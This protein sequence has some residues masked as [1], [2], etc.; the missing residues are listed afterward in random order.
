MGLQLW[1]QA[2]GSIEDPNWRVPD[3]RTFDQQYMGGGF[4]FG[5]PQAEF[6]DFSGPGGP[7]LESSKAWLDMKSLCGLRKCFIR[8]ESQRKFFYLAS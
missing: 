1:M 6:L 2:S 7:S 8:Y 3:Q 5:I 4:S